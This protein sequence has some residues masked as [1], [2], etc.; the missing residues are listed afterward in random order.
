MFDVI[1]THV[2]LLHMQPRL[3][4]C[5]LA[6]VVLVLSACQASAN[7]KASASANDARASSEESAPTAQ[8]Q[9]APSPEPA[10]APP[11]DACPLTCYEAQG[12]ARVPLSSDEHASLRSALA[13]MLGKM[14]SCGSSGGARRARSATI[15]LRLAPDGKLAELGVDPHHGGDEACLD[16][17]AQ[18]ASPSISLPGRKTVRCSEQCAGDKPRSGKRSKRA[19][20]AQKAPVPEGGETR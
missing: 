12:W 16:Q 9:A 18:G 4:Q 8:P 20:G 15:H 1:R 11:A 7:V 19:R 14:R 5:A 6:C 3:S 2:I 13:P 17:S 10:P